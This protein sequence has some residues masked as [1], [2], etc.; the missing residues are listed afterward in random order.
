MTKSYGPLRQRVKTLAHAPLSELVE[1]FGAWVSL[2]EDFGA[3]KRK[4][5]FSPLTHLL[6][7][8]LADLRRRR[9]VPRGRAQVSSL[10]G[11]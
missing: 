11:S 2:S 4:R 1:L 7:I 9:L 8:S 5:L 10:V 6:A 3:P